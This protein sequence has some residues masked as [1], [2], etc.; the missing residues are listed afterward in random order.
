MAGQNRL[1]NER[2]AA[3]MTECHALAADAK[4]WMNKFL[5]LEKKLNALDKDGT[6][7]K[8]A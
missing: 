3:K 4:R 2:L 1:L 5:K 7:E 6:F 8:G